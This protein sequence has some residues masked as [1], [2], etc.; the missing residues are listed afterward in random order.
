MSQCLG[1][2]PLVMSN[3][4]F[5]DT[6]HLLDKVGGLR[7]DPRFHLGYIKVEPTLGATVD[8]ALRV[9]LNQDIHPYSFVPGLRNLKPSIMPY[10]WIEE[11]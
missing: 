10:L 6:P 7:P 3:V 11:V 4:H 1:G 9:Q 8:A 5:L 2:A